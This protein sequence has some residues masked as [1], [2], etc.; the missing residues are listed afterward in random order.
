MKSFIRYIEESKFK[1]GD[2][3]RL[4]RQGSEVETVVKVTGNMIYTN[5]HMNSPVHATKLV[6]AEA[7]RNL[8]LSMKHPDS[9]KDEVIYAD[10]AAAS[11]QAT[12]R[13]FPIYLV[14]HMA[15]K[16]I[17]KIV[18]WNDFKK[19]SENNRET[20][21]MPHTPEFIRKYKID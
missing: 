2:K 12:Q 5:K 11:K 19:W 4:N 13:K 14:D 1:K 10:S 3:V 18:H 6:M 21:T 20:Y 8:K 15:N 17:A 7:V 16:I 9:P